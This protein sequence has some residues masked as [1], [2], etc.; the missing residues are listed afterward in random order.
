MRSRSSLT[1]LMPVLFS[2]ILTCSGASAAEEDKVFSVSISLVGDKPLLFGQKAYVLVRISNPQE[3]AI[4]YMPQGNVVCRT[5]V[6]LRREDI[7]MEP[8][9]RETADHFGPMY[10][11]QLRELQPG[12]SVGAVYPLSAAYGKL[13]VGEYKVVARVRQAKRGSALPTGKA[14]S[15]ELEFSVVG[16]DAKEIQS[17][18]FVAYFGEEEASLINT[19]EGQLLVRWRDPR[20]QDWD[21]VVP[22]AGSVPLSSLLWAVDEDTCLI[23]FRDRTGRSTEV[24]AAPRHTSA[25]ESFKLRG[26][27]AVI[28]RRRPYAFHNPEFCMRQKAARLEKPEQKEET[29]CRNSFELG[30]V[31]ALGAAHGG[32]SPWL[33]LRP[34]RRAA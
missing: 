34:K 32:A 2:A 19:T 1:V 28:D 12:E 21:C 27:M 23:A 33:L 25:V 4:A 8:S 7:V 5:S 30:L 3:E 31:C 15:N 20:S 10:R 26:G 14:V 17:R 18:R 9:R 29:A 24:F 11:D 16:W 22:V 6:E 13:P